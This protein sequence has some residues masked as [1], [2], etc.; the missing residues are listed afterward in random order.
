MVQPS[1]SLPLLFAAAAVGAAE[2]APSADLGGPVE[3][4][5]RTWFIANLAPDDQAVA[6]Q[7]PRRRELAIGTSRV[8]DAT[9]GLSMH[10]EGVWS[11]ARAARAEP[12]VRVDELRAGIGVGLEGGDDAL[13]WRLAATGA[14]RA[15]VDTHSRRLDRL[16]NGIFRGGSYRSEGDPQQPD[17][18]APLLAAQAGAV[19]RLTDKDPLR[20]AP[21]DVGLAVRATHLPTEGGEP[22]LRVQAMLLLPTRTTQSWFGFAWQGAGEA[23]DAPRA[24]A[25]VDDVEAG[26]WFVSGGSLRVG[27]A[28]DWLFEVGSALDLADGVAVGTLGVVRSGAGP[29][30]GEDGTSSLQAVLLRGDHTAAGIA[31]GDQLKVYGPLR[32]RSEIRTLIGDRHEPPGAVTAD[33]LRLDG[34]LRLQLP[35]TLA[36]HVSFGPE[37]AGGLGLRRDAVEFPDRTFA[38]LHRVVATGDVGV[39][40]RVATGWQGGIAALEASLGLAWWQA[41]GGEEL[42]AAPGFSAPVEDSGTGVIMRFGLLAVF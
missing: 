19:W 5:P 33:A 25:A 3:I 17:E 29:R 31:T 1:R 9:R 7:A 30:S 4:A 35:L 37:A 16:E 42:V 6:A 26:W 8:V 27:A 24:I 32:V 34:M 14:V 40:G 41:L 22:G 2:L 20:E 10:V 11:P 38:A 36:P 15:L 13:R 28:G 23:D 18:F 12:P 21:V 39:A